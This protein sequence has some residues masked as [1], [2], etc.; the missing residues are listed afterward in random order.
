MPIARP[1]CERPCCDVRAAGRWLG[2]A[3]TARHGS[4]LISTGT[5]A[6]QNWLLSSPGANI[7]G[8]RV[9]RE[10]SRY[11][12]MWAPGLDRICLSIATSSLCALLSLTTH[13]CGLLQL[14]NH[15][16]QT[17][18]TGSRSMHTQDATDCDASVL[19]ICFTSGSRASMARRP[20]A[21]T[22]KANEK[23]EPQSQHQ[24]SAANTQ[25]QPRK[26]TLKYEQN[27]KNSSSRDCV[28]AQGVKASS[29][30]CG[31]RGQFGPRNTVKEVTGAYV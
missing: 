6:A 28:C 4:V 27:G 3:S 7:T 10:L 24:P 12:F 16:L 14:P 11:Q 21:S 26:S 29:R 31:C 2:S 17:A 15:S 13:G 8:K 19:P 25:Q 5:T 9:D 1:P 23:P 18:D 22:T 30:G 20:T